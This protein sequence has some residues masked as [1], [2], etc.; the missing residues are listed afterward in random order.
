MMRRLRYSLPIF[1]LVAVLL[2]MSTAAAP[3]DTT[4]TVVDRVGSEQVELLRLLNSNSVKDQERAVGLIGTHAHTGRRNGDFFDPLI[5]PLH[6]L[7]L[8]G[9]TEELRIMAVSAL[10]SI[11]TEPA[12][13]GLQVQVDDIESAR[14]QKIARQALSTYETTRLAAKN[15]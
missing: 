6:G 10:Y 13:R 7:V 15:Q 12:M 9:Q 5:A 1:A 11:G 4:D 3:T 2:P 14:V 8:N